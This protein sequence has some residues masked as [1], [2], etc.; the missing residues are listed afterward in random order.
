M[1]GAEMMPE[2]IIENLERFAQASFPISETNGNVEIPS[3][4]WWH[5]R[6]VSQEGADAIRNCVGAS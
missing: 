3:D 2:K 5:W 6:F 4:L 1:G